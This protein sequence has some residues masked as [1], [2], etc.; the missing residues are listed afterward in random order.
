MERFMKSLHAGKNLDTML[1]FM[2]PEEVMENIVD[3][4]QCDKNVEKTYLKNVIS[5][6]LSTYMNSNYE[7]LAI[8]AVV[9][10]SGRMI[11]RTLTDDRVIS[12]NALG[13]RL[14]SGRLEKALEMFLAYD[15]YR[16]QSEVF[17][18]TEIL[19]PVYYDWMYITKSGDVWELC[20]TMPNSDDFSGFKIGFGVDWHT[21]S[22]VALNL[23]GESI[24]MMLWHSG[25]IFASRM[26]QNLCILWTGE[27]LTV[28][29]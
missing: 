15:S 4:T 9:D 27:D 17:T 19:K 12:A 23:H 25:G 8:N 6:F 14:E 29:T 10:S 22:L 21:K 24:Q 1:N 20:H 28:F 16:K 5:W 26:E 13:K 18:D 7:Q 3:T 2:F 11:S